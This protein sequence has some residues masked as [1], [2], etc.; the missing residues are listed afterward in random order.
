[1]AVFLLGSLMRG[2]VSA[3]GEFGAF[4]VSSAFQLYFYINIICEFVSTLKSKSDPSKVMKF[5]PLLVERASMTSTLP[6][7]SS[8]WIPRTTRPWQQADEW[9]LYRAVHE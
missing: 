6:Q 5:G 8:D 7:N 2:M 1:M 9:Y 4:A 3:T